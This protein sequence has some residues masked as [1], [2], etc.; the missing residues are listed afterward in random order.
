[1]I[2][3]INSKSEIIHELR[4]MGAKCD[5]LL[6][7]NLE[8]YNKQAAI[9]EI[10]NNNSS[11]MHHLIEK[12]SEFIIESIHQKNQDMLSDVNESASLSLYEASLGRTLWEKLDEDTRKFLLHGQSLYE[13]HKYSRSTEFGFIAVEYCKALENE[14]EKKIISRYLQDHDTIDYGGYDNL[15]TITR[16]RKI[17]LGEFCVILDKARKVKN[18]SDSLWF[19]KDFIKN[20]T[21]GKDRIFDYKGKLYEIKDK[22]RNPAAH[23]SKY[24]LDLLESF[25]SL[26]FEDKFLREFIEAIQPC[27]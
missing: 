22:Y 1:L 16:Q 23:P 11:E 20:N 3:R 17:T 2:E 10:L 13:H 19:F 12:N 24:P 7:I 6:S 9:I 26:L 8:T 4:S 15:K 14:Y 18:K 27:D 5:L 21:I 25:R